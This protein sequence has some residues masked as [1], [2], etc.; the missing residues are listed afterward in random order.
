MSESELKKYYKEKAKYPS[1]YDYDNDGNLIEKNKEGTVIK[2]IALPI[3]RPP[4][5]EEHDEIEKIRKEKI[6][7]AT[8]DFEIARK[9]LIDI[10]N[11]SDVLDSDIVIAN[12]KVSE[13]D[14]QLQAVR[15][16]LR[17]IN[18]ENGFNIKDLDFSKISEKRKYPFNIAILETRPFTLQE[19][20][21]RIGKVAT[22]PLISVAEAK[23]MEDAIIP[24]ILFEDPDTNDFGFLS[25]NWVV[26]IEFKGT[27]YHSAKQGVFAELA[28]S[29][30]DTANLE[31]IMLTETPD[32]INYTL[33]D[34]PG[35]STVND[36]KWNATIKGLLY[37]INIIKFTYPELK[38]RLLETKNA[39]LG[40]YI[41]DDNILGIGISL[42][43]IQSKNPINWTGQNL[44]GKSL[45]D[46]RQ[47]FK[48][49]I[50]KE[51]E[52]ST[53]PVTKRRTRR[54]VIENT[55]S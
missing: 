42:D 23:E 50:D 46:I 45:M 43:N 7:V 48:E 24:V 30:N 4:T 36:T 16:P 52:R 11:R 39:L 29:F 51:L 47:R 21:V 25:L 17:Y 37:D 26:N 2:T 31:K 8:K 44:L 9:E 55:P 14:I 32:E 38:L 28:K 13:A 10:I 53:K 34:V 19:Q 3:Y 1:R 54:V 5:F 15:F 12:K 6:A 33:E 27:K 40:A 22:K 35:D 20:Y 41:P 18:I 49:D